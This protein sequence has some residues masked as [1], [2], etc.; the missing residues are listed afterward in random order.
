MEKVI[1]GEKLQNTE[2]DFRETCFGICVKEDKMLLVKKY[3]Q[4]SFIGGG[5]EKGETHEEC[6]KR[7]F[8]EESGYDL[9]HIKPFVT[10]DC[11]W[12]AAGKY[13][14]ESLAHFYIVKVGEKICE[15]TEDGHVAEEVNVEDVENLLPLPYHKKA[16]ELF[17]KNLNYN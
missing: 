2:Y 10:V 3:E 14:L 9:L 1:I 7:E 16:L 5:I 6:L 12:L 11:F 8:I 4:Y 17:L 15:P 13:P